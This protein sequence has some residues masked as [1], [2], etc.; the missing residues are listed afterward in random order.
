M[1]RPTTSVRRLDAARSVRQRS[2][3][4]PHPG[5]TARP[6]Q[7]RR[8][9]GRLD[10]HRLPQQHG[11]SASTGCF[12]RT[13]T[14]FTSNPAGSTTR[15][16][17]TPARPN[18]AAAP[19]LQHHPPRRHRTRPP[20]AAPHGRPERRR[21]RHR[22]HPG[23][24]QRSPTRTPHTT[25][26]THRRSPHTTPPR[27]D[28]G[29]IPHPPPWGRQPA[30]TTRLQPGR[31]LQHPP[32]HLHHPTRR[33]EDRERHTPPEL[34]MPRLPQHPQTLQPAP[35]IPVMT[36][37]LHRQRQPQR[38]IRE[39]HP[40]HLERL[41]HP[42][43]TTLQPAQSSLRSDQR[44]PVMTHHPRQQPGLVLRPITFKHPST[45]QQPNLSRTPISLA[46]Q[47]YLALTVSNPQKGRTY[48]HP[49]D[50]HELRPTPHHR[51]QTRR[52]HPSRPRRTRRPPRHPNPPLR[53]RHQHPHPRR[54]PQHR[55][56]A[57]TSPPTASSSNPTNEAPTP[58][59]PS[60]S[61]PPTT[62]TPTN[63]PSSK[64]SSKPS[65]SNTTPNAGPTPADRPRNSKPAPHR[66]RHTDAPT[67]SGLM[68]P[69]SA[70]TPGLILRVPK[71]ARSS[72][73]SLGKRQQVA[74]TTRPS[75]RHRVPRRRSTGSADGRTRRTPAGR[76]PSPQ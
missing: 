46:S 13:T 56:I 30:M 71:T 51:P 9:W 12:A 32:I 54:P 75:P 67:S 57:S 49:R 24:P 3:F 31:V 28:P 25:T 17:D 45:L 11:P 58:T 21:V 18:R 7:T 29:Q 37:R 6:R 65:S 40:E 39:P 15:A 4:W 76:A 59:S 2:P 64:N 53:S 27:L 23:L 47:S 74:P 68:S 22:P 1:Q 5:D 70:A 26:T 14:S 73:A 16:H 50:R 52:P 20:P 72:D 36:P 55:D 34:L 8:W 44:L 38:P 10:P 61:K 48:G 33:V 69:Q 42:N 62:S 19:A 63:A 66:Q 43:P 41:R 60:P 35:H